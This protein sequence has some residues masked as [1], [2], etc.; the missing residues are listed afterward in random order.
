MA[1]TM[2]GRDPPGMNSRPS[3]LLPLATVVAAI[4]V[5]LAACSSTP[6]PTGAPQPVTASPTTVAQG[7]TPTPAAA[8]PSA[9]PLPEPTAEPIATPKPTT[10]PTPQP[11]F[12]PRE[13][14]LVDLL[15]QDAKERCAPRRSDLPSGVSAGIECRPTNGPAARVGVYVYPTDHDAAA[16]YFAR[17]AEHGVKPLTGDCVQGTPGDNAW[18]PGDLE[19][20]LEGDTDG[21]IVIDGKGYM[22]QRNGC[23]LD[24]GTANVR[25]TCD[26]GIYIGI[27]GRSGDI[28][29]LFDWAW[30]HAP[31]AEPE[32]PNGPGICDYLNG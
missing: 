15:R 7:P 9:T 14:A 13:A 25:I 24:G 16:A 12:S 32:M 6:S 20:E 5:A 1:V 21:A 30:T 11:T 28:A 8:A 23:F 27:L 26:G 22:A 10:R 3:P 4:A 17:L 31:D 18:M 29:E 2:A 19:P